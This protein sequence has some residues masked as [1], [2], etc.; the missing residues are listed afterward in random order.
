MTDSENVK[1]IVETSF[2]EAQACFKDCLSNNGVSYDL[3]WVFREDV[4]F[5]YDRIFIRAPVSA[6]NESRAKACY[7]LGQKRDVGVNL[8]GFCLLDSRLCCYI[9][10]PKD[11]L[12]SQYMLMSNVAVKYSWRTEFPE[13]KPISNALMW[14]IRAWQSSRARFSHF[15]NHIPSKYSLLPEYRADGG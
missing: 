5:I 4:I 12:E 14:R 7:E 11:D 6:E 3:L 8:H 13:A 9:A 10:L 2:E 1:S 15:D